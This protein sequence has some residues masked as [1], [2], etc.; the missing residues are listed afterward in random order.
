MK[1]CCSF[2]WSSCEKSINK[3]ISFHQVNF[4]FHQVSFFSLDIT[5]LILFLPH[6][7][8]LS[9]IYPNLHY[10]FLTIWSRKNQKTKMFVLQSNYHSKFSLKTLVSFSKLTVIIN[11]LAHK[12]ARNNFSIKHSFFSSIYIVF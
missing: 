11:S 5:N 8:A 7:P 10:K 12:V 6:L 2:K 1:I 4:I 9:N 3:K